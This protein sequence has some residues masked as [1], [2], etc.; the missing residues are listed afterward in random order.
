[1]DLSFDEVPNGFLT[2]LSYHEQKISTSELNDNE[3]LNEGL[4]S[5]LRIII[6]HPGI[7]AKAL[8]SLLKNRP[9]KTIE[10]QIKELVSQNL[11]ERRG[12][13]KTGGYFMSSDKRD[14]S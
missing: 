12:S 4:K 5:L 2:A 6:T 10:R 1:M 8:P 9:L 11:V 3:G 13:R 7:Q 14:N